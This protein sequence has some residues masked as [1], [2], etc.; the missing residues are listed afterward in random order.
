MNLLDIPLKSGES[1]DIRHQISDAI[2]KECRQSPSA[3]SADLEIAQTLRHRL[4]KVRSPVSIANCEDM[5]KYFVIADALSKRLSENSI[6]VEWNGESRLSI[7]FEQANV[8]I[9]MGLS[10]MNLGYRSPKSNDKTYKNAV[11]FYQSAAGCFQYAL[12][13][14]RG[15]IIEKNVNFLLRLLLAHAQ[16]VVWLKAVRGEL[17]DSAIARLLQGVS[18]L[19]DDCVAYSDEL[20]LS[21]VTV[22]RLHFAAAAMFRQSNVMQENRE[23]GQQV[24]SLI[25]AQNLCATATNSTAGIDC[26]IAQDLMGLMNAIKEQSRVAAR[27][28]NLVHMQAVPPVPK[29]VASLILCVPIVPPQL[30]QETGEFSD[31]VPGIVESVSR[32][33][34]SRVSDFLALL[35]N[36]PVQELDYRVAAT[37]DSRKLPSSLDTVQHPENIPKTILK[38]AKELSDAGGP[39]AVEQNLK[40]LAEVRQLCRAIKKKC[41]SSFANQTPPEPLAI[42]LDFMRMYLDQAEEG[43]S[44]VTVAFSNLRPRLQVFESIDLLK[45]YIPDATYNLPPQEV[46]DIC[47]NLRAVILVGESLKSRRRGIL[48]DLMSGIKQEPIELKVLEAYKTSPALFCDDSGAIDP[49]TFESVYDKYIE[50]L[51]DGVRLIENTRAAQEQWERDLESVYLA[52]Q[53]QV[54]F[55]HDSQTKR[56]Q[57]LHSLETTYAEYKELIMSINEGFEFYND[58]ENRGRAVLRECEAQGA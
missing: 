6:K 44:T 32:A 34:A 53:D 23:Y 43:D 8:L 50:K 5:A 52:F 19:Y 1:T 51:T 46:Q 28:N 41:V 12:D 14:F 13:R 42:K 56:H 18:Q 15:N 10:Y 47:E 22:K 24:S 49:T 16:E 3:F 26:T 39:S 29:P 2:I 37:L 11:A 36:G 45:G 27:S 48:V 38:Y 30:Y 17:K 9:Q 58:F 31:L 55:T 57:A 35:C 54:S 7:R 40:S 21:H 4:E 20:H 25:C 33:F